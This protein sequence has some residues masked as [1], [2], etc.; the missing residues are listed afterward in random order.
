MQNK[1][2]K[3]IRLK[4]KI[5]AKIRGSKEQPRLTV[6]RSNK[7]IYA[8]VVDD[9]SGKTLA[10]ASDIKITKGTKTERAKEVGKMIGQ[11]CLKEKISKV[12]FD[13]NGFKY[14]GRIKLVAD[15]ARAGGLK[16]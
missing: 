13:R 11:A 4:A 14:T 9:L 3:R 12:V 10:Q 2:E 7:F 6:F 1:S 16:F 5:R 15:E 8:Q